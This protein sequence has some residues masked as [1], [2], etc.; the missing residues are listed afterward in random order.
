MLLHDKSYR[1][2][3]FISTYNG[4]YVCNVEAHVMVSSYALG[5]FCFIVWK[6]KMERKHIIIPYCG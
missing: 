5:L 2:E 3:L 1:Y 6:N 4:W